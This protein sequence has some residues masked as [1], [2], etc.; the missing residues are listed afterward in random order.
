M[1]HLRSPLRGQTLRF[2]HGGGRVIPLLL[3]ALVFWG[4][5]GA[6]V[7]E[8]VPAFQLGVI[9]AEQQTLTAFA[10]VNDF[11]RGQQIQRAMQQPSLRE[12]FFFEPLESGD[13]DRW[14]RAFG[15][16][17]RYAETLE[18]LLDPEQREKA[19][20]HINALSESLMVVREDSVPPG[21]G[22]VFARLSSFL[23]TRRAHRE[24]L[25]IV[26]HVNPAIQDIF[27]V[28][29]G[30]IGEHSQEG[31]RGTVWTAWTQKLAAIDVRQF[32]PADTDEAKLDAITHYIDVMAQRDSH[33]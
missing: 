24:A 14:T 19:E 33:V 32:R 25:E 10:T 23:M 15:L 30:A 22:A 18:A 8:D 21:L 17:Q 7:R 9:T 6:I 12:V 3:A 16:M 1:L 5:N 13:I 29:M 20:S 2:S 28:M 27:R 4:C 11:L 31:I 26:R